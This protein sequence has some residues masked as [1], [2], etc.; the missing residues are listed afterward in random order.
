MVVASAAQHAILQQMIQQFDAPP[1]ADRQLKY[2]PLPERETGDLENILQTFVPKATIQLQSDSRR[3]MVIATASEQETIERLLSQLSTTATDTPQKQLRVF[4]V[5]PEQRRQFV[6][7]YKQ[8]SPELTTITILES[9]QPNELQIVAR[10][11]Q[12]QRVAELLQELKEQFPDE[13]RQLKFYD[14]TPALRARFSALKDQLAPELRDVQVLDGDQP[15]RMGLVA[16][17]IE[18]ARATDLLQ[19]L[20]S[21]LPV[22]ESQLQ[23]YAVTPSQRK[24]FLAILPSLQNELPGIRLVETSLPTELTIWARPAQHERLNEVLQSLRDV[25]STPSLQLVA[26][27]VEQ[28]DPTSIQTVLQE[29]YPDTKIVADQESG[30][31][32]VWT[33]PAEH[34]QIEQAVQQMDAPAA[35]GKNKMVYYQL[36]EIDARDVV[37]MFQELAPDMSLVADRDSNSI[38]AWGT[39]KDHELLAKTVEDFRQQ[40][41]EGRRTIVSYPYGNRS[42]RDVQFLLQELVPNARVTGDR[43]R[44]MI[45][46]WATPEEHELIQQAM[47]KL[48]GGETE[49][50][51]ELRVYT[52]TRMRANDVVEALQQIA[53]NAQ[54]S[55]SSDRGQI[56]VWADAATHDQ[57]R[58]AVEKIEV[59][60]P[61]AQK[62]AV[63]IY[64]GRPEIL[65]RV[66]GLLE[67][68]APAPKRF[69][70]PR[71]TD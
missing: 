8:I 64:Q 47:L 71:P 39:E 44:R 1:A 54:I 7:T 58:A 62:G 3:L 57:I 37:Q 59:G 68:I 42:T 33:T 69:P 16:T 51:G 14:V 6:S 10:E 5:T 28:G 2:Y 38:I 27:P 4:T 26:Y 32:L 43:T 30:R 41:G 40:A 12:Q 13:L 70:T 22:Q 63:R 45:I 65:K 53:P 15:D 61:D 24:R 34:E 49:G 46:V 50:S 23:V 36:G 35:A 66:R 11:D 55:V 60:D 19:Q 25:E 56:L 31:V 67:E 52:I 48:T 17:D 29:L 20:R 21:E 9:S 18:H